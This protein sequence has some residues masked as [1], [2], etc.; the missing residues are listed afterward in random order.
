[1]S[2]EVLRLV[3]VCQRALCKEL[4]R[5]VSPEKAS[6]I[7]WEA[8]EA[9]LAKG[10]VRSPFQTEPLLGSFVWQRRARQRNRRSPCGTGSLKR[11]RQQLAQTA[12][13]FIVALPRVLSIEQN[14]A[15][16]RDYVAEELTAC[17][18]VVDWVCSRSGG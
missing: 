16:V 8:T 7:D 12:R 4:I 2:R 14:I 10:I 6:S 18:F 5:K 13:K 15:L 1:M 3:S 11:K 9:K 17:G